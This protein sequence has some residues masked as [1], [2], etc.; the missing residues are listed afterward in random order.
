MS[1]EYYLK[2]KSQGLC[3]RC[4]D[5]AIEGKVLC[6]QCRDK[7]NEEAREARQMYKRLHICPRCRTAS[8][9]ANE[10]ICPD[11]L[12]KARVYNKE[13]KSEGWYRKD[14]DRLNALGICRCC[15][16]RPRA[17]DR[18]YC[19]VCIAKRKEIYRKKHPR[20]TERHEYGLCYRC[21]KQLDRE[22]TLC[23]SC[24]ETS[25]NNLQKGERNNANHIWRKDNMVTFLN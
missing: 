10:K 14:Q 23:V 16:K 19:S 3:V 1:K 15:R 6:P 18:T 12:E 4:G 21:G 9:Y 25:V 22:G 17:K 2:R 13:H 20:R 8:L 24:S 5:K 7:A 11:C